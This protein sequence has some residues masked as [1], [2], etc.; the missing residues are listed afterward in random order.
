MV[1]VPT[2]IRKLE[3]LKLSYDKHCAHDRTF[4]KDADYTLAFPDGTEI[5]TLPDHRGQ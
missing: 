3:L 5:I 2:T 4:D 1:R